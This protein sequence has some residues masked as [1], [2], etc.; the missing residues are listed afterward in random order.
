MTSKTAP[1]DSFF[2][3]SGDFTDRRLSPRPGDGT[4]LYRLNRTV[5]NLYPDADTAD[6]KDRIDSQIVYGERVAVHQTD[7]DK[8]QISSLTDGYL[9]WIDADAIEPTFDEPAN[10]WVST[11]IAHLY[12]APNFKQA[13]PR[14]VT[15]GA[16]LLVK[17][18][19]LANG[20][21]KTH[22]GAYIYAKHVRPVGH[23]FDDPL[24]V[25]QTLMH[26]PYLWGGRTALGLDCSALVQLSF[27]ACGVALHRDS[28]LQL[29]HHGSETQ[30][31]QRGDLAFF[32][33][34]V[35]LM[36][37]E[38]HMIHANATHMKVTLDPVSD[39]ID[40]IRQ[41]GKADPFS[42]YRRL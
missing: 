20:F 26:S 11:P 13:N 2:T 35:G 36:V 25:A 3:G 24:G 30:S 15:L 32:P 4:P 12:T 37:D 17:G 29:A 10:F 27:A 19:T 7:G 38:N 31:P 34:H 41:E 23:W 14:T 5:T 16:Q 40:W 21:L 28:D 33:G 6:T 42:G 18:A 1:Q 8:A 9:G 39:V 22:D